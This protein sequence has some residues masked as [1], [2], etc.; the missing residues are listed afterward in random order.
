MDRRDAARRPRGRA[1][2]RRGRARPTGARPTA[3]VERARGRE[4]GRGGAEE[5][6]GNAQQ[7][8]LARAA[9]AGGLEER[10]LGEVAWR[11][12][13]RGPAARHRHD[14]V[15]GRPS[16]TATAVPTRPAPTTATFM[17]PVCRLS[18][19]TRW[20]RRR[21]APRPGGSSGVEPARR[22]APTATAVVDE[23]RPVVGD[24]RD[25]TASVDGRREPRARSSGDGPASSS[26]TPRRPVGRPYEA[27]VASGTT[28]GRRPRVNVS[29]RARR[30]SAV[31]REPA[32][33]HPV[34]PA[35][36]SEDELGGPPRR[37][38]TR[39]TSRSAAGETAAS[40]Y[41]SSTRW[42]RPRPANTSA[43]EPAATA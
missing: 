43:R 17:G 30:G 19:S 32:E 38:R 3:R 12:V 4:V 37:G 35:A 7:H 41:P 21:G 33:E 6:V 26:Y 10:R 24:V 39:T 27:T 28:R 25:Q 23:A 5:I 29:G 34:R 36:P 1:R 40:A 22:R 42:K 11:P 13:P 8:E 31:R 16:S 2:A 9:A 18:G 15:P 14:L 20:D